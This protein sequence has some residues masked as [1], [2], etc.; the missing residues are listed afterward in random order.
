LTPVKRPSAWRV[1]PA[2]RTSFKQP[3]HPDKADRLL[4]RTFV[5]ELADPASLAQDLL[6]V[7][8]SAA[9]VLDEGDLPEDW[10]PIRTPPPRLRRPFPES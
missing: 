3:R 6:E 4:A 2:P 8:L 5:S 7:D 9:G 10:E 1:K